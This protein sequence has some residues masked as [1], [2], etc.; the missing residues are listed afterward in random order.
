MFTDRS[1]VIERIHR[2]IGMWPPP[3]RPPKAR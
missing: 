2:E 3:E 1:A